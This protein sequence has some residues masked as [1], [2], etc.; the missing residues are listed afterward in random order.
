MTRISELDLNLLPVLDR[1]L[2][3]QSVSAAA[4]DLGLS[5]P[6]TSRALIRLREA[7]GDALLVRAGRGM[8]LTPRARELVEP[9]QQAMAAASRVFEPA[10]H[11]DPASATGELILALGEEAE[12]AFADTIA[13]A[14]RAFAPGVNL[15]LRALGM[16][17]IEEAR[18][19]AVDLALSP[20]LAALPGSAGR[21]DLS[22]F[23]HRQLYRRRWVVVAA[24]GRRRSVELDDYL[25]ADHVIVSFSAGG[26][27][28]VD[29]LLA[30]RGL[31]RRVAVSVTSFPSAARLVA[32][33]SLLSLLPEELLHISPGLDGFPPPLPIPDLPME[34]IW[35][36]RHT[37]DARHRALRERVA[38]AIQA[39]VS[40]W[41]PPAPPAG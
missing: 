39:R 38:Q 15:R 23:V 7:L 6:A 14:L 20:D 11:F 8:V 26:H 25:A 1:L 33:S 28:F 3:R 19:G 30:E 22:A 4:A 31:R 41:A 10:P 21:A 27:G 17:T 13:L 34:L 36:P 2:A 35:H 5:Q 29:D 12:A 18:R 40:S 32:S 24:A 37:T 16:H 9:V